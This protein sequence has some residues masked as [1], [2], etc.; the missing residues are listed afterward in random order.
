[1]ENSLGGELHKYEVLLITKRSVLNCC[2]NNYLLVQWHPAAQKAC[3]C[4]FHI[5]SHALGAD[6]A[7]KQGICKKMG[8]ISIRKVLKS[9]EK[10][11][12]RLEI[13]SNGTISRQ[14]VF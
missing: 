13:V 7:S 11:K 12:S 2:L 4:L 1:M 10:V 6:R 3:A 8:K 14:G 9:V 5:T